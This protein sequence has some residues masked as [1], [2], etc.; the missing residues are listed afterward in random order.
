MEP[1]GFLKDVS[2]SRT[3]SSTWALTAIAFNKRWASKHYWG[4]EPSWQVIS[5]ILQDHCWH[6]H[7]LH[8]YPPYSLVLKLWCRCWLAVNQLSCVQANGAA[9]EDVAH[10]I[11]LGG[12]TE[13]HRWLVHHPFV[14]DGVCGLWKITI[15]ILVYKNTANAL[16]A[17]HIK[18]VIII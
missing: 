3:L 1:L 14:A 10:W 16:F 11:G 13:A 18:T 17:V 8:L 15:L 4:P 7:S 2:S 6:R 12:C 5:D 9:C